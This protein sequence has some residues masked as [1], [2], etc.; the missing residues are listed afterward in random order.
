[1]AKVKHNNLIDTLN[2][3]AEDA[4]SKGVIQ[5]HSEDERFTGRTIH[6]KGS[7]L[8]HFATTGY[9]GLE[10]DSRLK[11]AAI[12]AIQKYGTQFPLSKS[13][14]SHPLYSSLEEKLQTMYELPVLV[15]K[16]STLGHMGVIPTIVREEDAVVLDHHVH[17]SVQNATLLLK[18]R[19]IEVDM[20]RH[21]N[22]NMLEDRIKSLR[23]RK[24]KIWYFA[25]GIYSMFG[26]TAPMDE[27]KA[28]CGK[29]PQLYL[30]FDDVH[31][32][33]WV[34]K[35][36]TGFV[37]SH[38]DP[39]P[40]NVFIFSTL[41]KT[42]GASGGTLVTSN[43]AY[44]KKVKNFG[45]P[46]TFSAQLEPASVAAAIAS[47][48]IH[49]SPEIYELQ[50]DLHKKINYCNELLAK[51]SLPLVDVND[52]PVFY[53]GTGAPAVGYNFVNKLYK[54]GFYVNMGIFPAVPVKKTGV[55]FTICRHN[56][57]EDIEALVKAMDKHYPVSLAEESYST[58]QVRRLFGLPSLTEDPVEISPASSGLQLVFADK[59][60]DLKKED[61]DS[62]YGNEGLLSYAGLSFLERAFQGNEDKESNWQFYYLMVKDERH[63]VLAS[64]FLTHCWWKD[65]MLAPASV[66]R[67]FEEKRLAD[68][69]YMTSRVL[70]TGSMFTEGDHL[71]LNR[72]DP[73]WEEAL[74]MIIS[75]ME[76]L[77]DQLNPATVVLR[78]FDTDDKLFE[79]Y[80]IKK[81]FFRVTL[82][83][84]CVLEKLEWNTREEYLANLS[85]RS[86]KHFRQDIEPYT[87]FFDVIYKSQLDEAEISHFAG[88]YKN[89]WR[90]NYDMNSFPFNCGLFKS[91]SDD[92]NWEFIILKLKEAHDER[93]EKGTPVAVMFCF[94]EN[95]TYVPAFIGMDYEFL[96]KYQTYRQ[97]LW[98]TIVRAKELGSSRINFGFSS[99]FEKRKVGAS[100][101]PKV[102]YMQSKDNYSLEMIGIVQKQ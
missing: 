74:N 59:L 100:I 65:D 5:L 53:V 9:L 44:F 80:I 40:E 54:A 26:D 101:F 23:S 45:G 1:M 66:S 31:G 29:Y 97:M 67:D 81:G 78:D 68:P 38:F 34:G 50:E 92:P 32:M 73:R 22:M 102:A 25:D 11:S 30:Y 35:N 36:G 61:W 70:M 19:G 71:Y 89:V 72:E 2:T 17:W 10:Q 86:R 57:Y 55:R 95:S 15:M 20:I 37:R 24:E 76:E 4:I 84:S 14:V 27:L 46:L 94:K 63:K 85:A 77:D 96:E 99:S 18:N 88:L 12:E 42:F 39:L 56:T 3:I 8:L 82:P 7:E 16:N 90:R 93:E 83:D 41:S 98:Q 62:V 49:L 58:N 64:V 21:N 60:A 48:D 6:I 79:D 75:R 43:T 69:G 52:C 91:M 33:S 87:R 13:Y 28:L 51:T 47:A